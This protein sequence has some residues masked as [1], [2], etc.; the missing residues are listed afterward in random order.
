MTD[1]IGQD[2][3]TAVISNLKEIVINVDPLEREDET[4]ESVSET[5]DKP[6]QRARGAVIRIPIR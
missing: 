2:A 4:R 3:L 1:E 6:H 5:Q